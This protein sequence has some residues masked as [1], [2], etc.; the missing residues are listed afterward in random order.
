VILPC[1]SWRQGILFTNC[2]IKAMSLSKMTHPTPFEIADL[3]SFYQ[4]DNVMPKGEK[5]E[6]AKAASF[7]H[8]MW[9]NRQQ[10]RSKSRCFKPPEDTIFRPIAPFNVFSVQEG[11]EYLTKHKLL[12]PQN[13]F[14]DVQIASAFT[15]LD[16]ETAKDKAKKRKMTVHM[17]SGSHLFKLR[18]KVDE[19]SLDYLR[20]HLN[21]IG[22]QNFM[23]GV[24]DKKNKRQEYDSIQ[25]ES[26]FQKYLRN[27]WKQKRVLELGVLT[28]KR[29]RRTKSTY[30]A[31]WEQ[32]RKKVKK[33]IGTSILRAS[34]RKREKK[35]RKRYEPEPE[36]MY[37]RSRTPRKRKTKKVHIVSAYSPPPPAVVEEVISAEVISYSPEPVVPVQAP[38]PNPVQEDDALYQVEMILDDRFNDDSQRK[39]WLVKW[40]GYTVEES[41]WEP[42]ENVDGN[43]KF[44]DYQDA[45]TAEVGNMA[46]AS[47]QDTEELNAA[48]ALA[49][50]AVPSDVWF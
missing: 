13:G 44:A 27:A 22:V 15:M 43:V 38:E 48:N 36:P 2:D 31:S 28:S 33:E 12:A 11:S 42:L 23:L 16:E 1:E 34:R 50:E 49:P 17:S 30:D 10:F 7:A 39:E 21:N 32:P 29:R 9:K 18:L 20:S 5:E 45:K 25:S 14:G 19:F 41:T 47:V 35:A 6:I 46:G 37:Q 24:K 8:Y 3:I 4:S 26:E 40:E